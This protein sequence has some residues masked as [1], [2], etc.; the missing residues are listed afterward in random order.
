MHHDLNIHLQKNPY[1]E[2]KVNF[3]VS[4]ISYKV[5]GCG[6]HDPHVPE[7]ESEIEG[8]KLQTSTGIYSKKLAIQKTEAV[9]EEV[10]SYSPSRIL[11]CFERMKRHI[12]PV[13]LLA[14]SFQQ[15]PQELFSH[16]EMCR[17][18]HSTAEHSMKYS[19]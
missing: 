14:I 5:D 8:K 18:R 17:G 12:L 13:I 9:E 15:M 4:K 19:H 3:Q 11:S 10:V 6:E 7:D 1:A 16:H 2:E